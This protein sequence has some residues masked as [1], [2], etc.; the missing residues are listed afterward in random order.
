MSA[1]IQRTPWFSLTIW[2]NVLRFCTNS[3]A[4]SM[5]ALRKPDA[6]RRDDGTGR[7]ERLHHVLEAAA[8]LAEQV[9]RGHEGVLEKSSEE[10]TPRPPIFSSLRPIT[11]PG[12]GALHDEELDRV[13]IVAAGLRGDDDEI[14]I[15]CP[16]APDLRAADAIAA[17]DAASR[18]VR[19]PA[20]SEP[21]CGSVTAIAARASPVARP[22]SS[23]VFCSAVPAAQDRAER[24]PLDGQQIGRVVAD[25][26]K[27]LDRDAGR[28]Q[29]CRCRR[30]RSGRAG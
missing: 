11:S 2:P 28:Q 10:G 24:R 4:W 8:L 14:G 25:A 20:T 22:G 17:V 6:A 30:I 12:V 9:L 23:R 7:V 26:A 27:L 15:G 13:A 19:M 29:C 3:I 1:S 18:G 21:L 5:R 16:G